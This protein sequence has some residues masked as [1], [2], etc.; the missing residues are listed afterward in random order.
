MR[1]TQSMLRNRGT[2]QKEKIPEDLNESIVKNII[3]HKKSENSW[4]L[5]SKV[6]QVGKSVVKV[7]E[8]LKWL[9]IQM[10]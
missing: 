7:S 4:F 10:E 1:R 8:K 6:K 5:K 2:I 3:K 9:D